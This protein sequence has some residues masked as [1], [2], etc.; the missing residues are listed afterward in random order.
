MPQLI[1]FVDAL[2]FDD[3]ARMPRLAAW[4]W[5]ARLRPGFGY[6]INLHPELF[7]G[8]DPDAVGFFGEWALDRERAPGRRYRRLL[9]LLDRVCRPYV[10]NRGLQTLLTRRYRPDRIMPNLPLGWLGDFAIH[11]EKVADPAFGHPTLFTRHPGLVTVA[12]E[13]LAKGRRDRLLVERAAALVAGGARQV[14]LPLPDLDGIGHADRR[15]GPRWGAHLGALDAWVDDLAG[16]F[17]A[18]HPGGDVFV[19]SDH[20]M[21]DVRAGVAF[22]IEA[23][24]GP[25]GWDR[26]HYFTDSTLLRV[27]VHDPELGPAIA[28]HIQRSEV[29]ALVTHAERVAY[30]LT[31][32]RFGDFIAVLDEGLCFRPSTFARNIPAA[33]HGYHPDAASQ[34]AVLLHRGAR[35]PAEAVARTIDVFGILDAALAGDRG[36]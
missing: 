16:A 26:Y 33:M 12:I 4:P 25:P 18:R 1:V 23:E 19:V 6:S 32:P 17:L 28:D 35:P 11:G 29:A 14:Y 5:Q 27:W 21:A 3:L 8:L 22:G 24:I 7:A 15:S 20:G 30:G 13:G 31:N 34:H 10:L 2:P 9:P 36:V